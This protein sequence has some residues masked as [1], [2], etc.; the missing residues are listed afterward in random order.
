MLYRIT[1][2]AG[3][4]RAELFH[5][6]T[7]E[8]SREFFA[9]VAEAAQRRRCNSILISVRSS[10]PLFT[11][12]RSGFFAEFALL[13]SSQ[14]RKV[15]LVADSEELDYSHEYFALLAQHQGMN[16][17]HFRSEVAALDWLRPQ[18]LETAQDGYYGQRSHL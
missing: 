12:D 7:A 8:E 15:A 14:D 17:G 13:D 16:V 4:L 6:E 11:V 3:Y 18:S 2:E 1:S 5:R 10:S 9:A